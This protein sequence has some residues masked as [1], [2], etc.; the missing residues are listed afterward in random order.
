M[1]KKIAKTDQDIHRIYE[2]AID[3]FAE[4]INQPL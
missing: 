4:I 3:R 2:D 1:M